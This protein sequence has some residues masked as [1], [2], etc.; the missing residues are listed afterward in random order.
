MHLDKYI[1]EFSEKQKQGAEEACK[2]TQDVCCSAVIQFIGTRNATTADTHWVSPTY[3]FRANPSTSQLKSTGFLMARDLLSNHECQ[4][5][6][7]DLN[8]T[9]LNKTIIGTRVKL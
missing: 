9:G 2:R 8:E 4:Q 6:Y 5:C 1:S 7:E 3:R